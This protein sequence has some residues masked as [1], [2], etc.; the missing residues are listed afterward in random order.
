MLY[1][2]DKDTYLDIS[3]GVLRNL[4]GITN[5]DELEQV[6]AELTTIE[7]A[8]ITTEE[9]PPLD[10]FNWKLL[11]RV[12][13][14]LFDDIYEWAGKP[15]TIE[16]SKDATSFARAI[17]IESSANIV[18]DQLAKENFLVDLHQKEFAQRIAHFYSELNVIHPYREGNGRAIRTFLS[19]HADKV[20]WLIRWDNM[21]AAQNISACETAYLEDECQLESMLSD[22]IEPTDRS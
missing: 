20:G 1:D 9:Y 15:R 6:E 16:L 4:L 7:I 14:R 21:S 2:V 11:C 8:A 5:K 12:H 19:M 10:D 17:H 22:L 13:K 3:S 18:F